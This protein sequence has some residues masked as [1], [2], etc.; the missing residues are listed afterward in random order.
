MVLSDIDDLSKICKGLEQKLEQ[1]VEEAKT[2]RKHKVAGEE[3]FRRQSE[4]LKEAQRSADVAGKES[5]ELLAQVL[6]LQK[7][8]DSLDDGE[9]GQKMRQLSHDLEVWVTRHYSQLLPGN[10]NTRIKGDESSLDDT[11]HLGAVY[12]I[13]ADVTGFIFNMILARFMIGITE[14]SWDDSFYELDEE[15]RKLCGLTHPTLFPEDCQSS[16]M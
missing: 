6:R 10:S 13:W 2:L 15:V 11:Q 5:R 8:T 4:L 16:L 14:R 3:R 7:W 9:A 1:V 12:A